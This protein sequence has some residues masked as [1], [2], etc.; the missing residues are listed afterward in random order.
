MKYFESMKRIGCVL[1]VTLSCLSSGVVTAQTADPTGRVK[2]ILMTADPPGRV[3]TILIIK[4]RV[5]IPASDPRIRSFGLSS[6]I[7]KGFPGNL[8]PCNRYRYPMP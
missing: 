5:E 2:T 7:L 1:L 3:K 4:G 6:V 8:L